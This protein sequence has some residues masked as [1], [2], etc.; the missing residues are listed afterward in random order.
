[1][2]RSPKSKRSSKNTFKAHKNLARTHTGLSLI[3]R[4]QHVLAKTKLLPR[5]SKMVIAVSGGPDSMTL[6]TLLARLREK[7][8]FTLHVVHVN[9]ELRGRY[10]A[11]DEAL[12][13][14]T[15]EAYGVPLSVFYPNV[16]PKTNIEAHL[17]DIRY[18]LFEEVRQELKFDCIVTGHTMNDL[19]ETFLLNLL[20]GSGERGLSPFQR[21]HSRLVR[22]L[23]SFTRHDIETFLKTE[24]IE[25]RIDRSNFSKK[26]TRNRIRHELIPLLETFNPSI[27]ETLAQTV[28]RLGETM[29]NQ[30]ELRA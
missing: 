1:M 26:F 15:C 11:L 8:H 2:K 12:V 29:G 13:Q 27:V 24:K 10:S 9:Y 17:R 7:H 20:R 6:L 3:R 5:A 14:T 18:K 22:P 19:A 23:L 30:Q 28:R 21:K 25:A 4:F 16:K